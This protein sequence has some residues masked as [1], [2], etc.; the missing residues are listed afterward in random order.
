MDSFAMAETS[1][2]FHALD[3]RHQETNMPTTARARLSGIAVGTI[4]QCRHFARRF[5]RVGVLRR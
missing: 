1:L 5:G 2:D 3:N 4:E